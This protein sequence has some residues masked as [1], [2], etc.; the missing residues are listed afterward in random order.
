M[1]KTYKLKGAWKGK[2]AGG[3]Q[4]HPTWRY[5]PQLFLSATEEKKVTITLQQ[6]PHVGKSGN[7]E[8]IVV[9]VVVVLC[10]VVFCC[11]LFCFQKKNL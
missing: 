7:Q 10:F 9:V 6:E 5:N 11:V 3:C 1:S 4:N 8:V 2:S